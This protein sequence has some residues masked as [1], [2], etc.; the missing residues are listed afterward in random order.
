[1]A[2]YEN[3]YHFVTDPH[4]PRDGVPRDEYLRSIVQEGP[5]AAPEV[6]LFGVAADFCNRYAM[7]GWVARGARV[8]ILCDLTR[9]IGKE[10]P[11]VLAEERYRSIGPGSVRV[12][13]SQQF[14]EEC[15]PCR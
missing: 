15:A 1:M 7:E 3:L 11:A 8:T 12:M 9:G 10:W 2:A 4:D 14:L 5:G 13:S 6:T